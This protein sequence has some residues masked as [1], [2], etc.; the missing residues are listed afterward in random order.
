MY[1]HRSLLYLYQDFGAI[2]E[3]HECLRGLCHDFRFFVE[4][5]VLDYVGVPFDDELL[6]ESGR[7]AVAG[8]DEVQELVEPYEIECPT[9]VEL[10]GVG[11]HLLL[12]EDASGVQHGGP[13]CGLA[14]REGISKGLCGEVPLVGEQ[15]VPYGPEERDSAIEMRDRELAVIVLAGVEVGGE[16]LYLQGAAFNTSS[17]RL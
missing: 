14:A 7:G 2:Y 1:I 3:I 4:I 10:G 16:L 13:Y 11:L 12:V 5:Q 8:S 9:P 15:L 6:Y 17:M